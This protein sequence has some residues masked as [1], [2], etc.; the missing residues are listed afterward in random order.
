MNRNSTN[1]P[2]ELYHQLKTAMDTSEL[3]DKLQ[4][5][6]RLVLESIKLLKK[7]LFLWH[8]MGLGKTIL[9]VA[10]AHVCSKLDYLIVCIVPKSL[11][12]NF[13]TVIKEY[14][15]IMKDTPGFK[16]VDE[17]IFNFVTKSHIVNKNLAKIVSPQQMFE[18]DRTPVKINKITRKTI[19][20]IDEAHQV[21]Q[22]ISNGSEEWTHFYF[23]VMNSPLVRVFMLSG[24]LFS[25]S[26]FELVPIANMISG[27]ELFPENYEQ[28]MSTFWDQTGRKMKNRGIFQNRLN[29]LFSRM[30]LTYLEKETVNLYPEAKTTEVVR[31]KMGKYQYESYMLAREKEVEDKRINKERASRPIVKKFESPTKDSGSYR[32][33]S[34]Q[35]SNFAPPPE[36]EELYSN[37]DY[38]KEQLNHILSKVSSDYFDISKLIEVHKLAAKHKGSKG[39][40]Y[41]QFVGIG[42]GGAL[43]ESFRRIGYTDYDGKVDKSKPRFAMVN[44]SL[45]MEEQKKIIDTYN[46]VENDD[47]SIIEFIIVGIEQTTGLDLKCVG[48]VVM[49]EP[50]WNDFIRAQLFARAIRYKSHIRLPVEKRM[51]YTYIMLS[52]YPDDVDERIIKKKEF[53]LTTDEHLYRSMQ[54]DAAQAEEFKQPIIEVAIECQFI[55]EKNPDHVCR[56]CAPNN[57]Q[58]Y[59][60]G[61]DANQ[62][63]V[64]DSSRCDPCDQSAKEEVQAVVV[65]FGDSE[66]YGVADDNKYGYL[67]FYKVGS[68]YEEIKPSSPIFHQVLEVLKKKN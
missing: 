17:S 63:I 10:I 40:I 27:E 34:R 8:D 39:L 49:L 9:A 43:A 36:V 22:L 16:P 32:V 26:P 65:K 11:Q 3:S 5:H 48:W 56:V 38:T 4:Y 53:R 18:T 46:S 37:G 25:S 41:S 67:I 1:F 55:K 24:S 30:S 31:C 66:Y 14:N 13:K 60:T 6:Q 23:T 58:L 42:G 7:G 50:F 28:F 68:E 2:S 54:Y 35:Y 33:R 59:T 51:V 45:S 20:I 62:A 44:G 12:D 57:K 61:M 29:G 19:F 64:Y 21:S 15:N 52:V 47:G